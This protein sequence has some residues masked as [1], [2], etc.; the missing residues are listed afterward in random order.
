MKSKY[1]AP[2][3][4]QI[5]AL[6]KQGY[7]CHQHAAAPAVICWKH[8][9]VR[10]QSRFYVK[11]FSLTAD[12][13]LLNGYF[14]SQSSA[15]KYISDLLQRLVNRIEEKE[16]R[17]AERKSYD[18]TKHWTPGDVVYNSWG[19]DQ[20]NVDFYQVTRVSKGCIWIREISA[21]SSD[22]GQPGGG[23]CFPRRNEFIGEEI[24][25]NVTS[26]YVSFP[27]GA[28]CKWDGRAKY[29]SSDR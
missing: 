21:N 26:D 7:F 16:K 2:R 13:P 24:K 6:K 23:K 5:E 28:G 11:I 10:D 22:H 20:T 14:R 8:E 12:V 19:Y 29:C 1:H 25:K 3:N 27:C 9:I 15:E 4:T 18:C 17:K